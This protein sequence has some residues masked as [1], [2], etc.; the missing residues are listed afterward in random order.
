MRS[1]VV[2]LRGIISFAF[3]DWTKMERGSPCR[4]L[5]PIGTRTPSSKCPM[6]TLSTLIVAPNARY[7]DDPK[8]LQLQGRSQLATRWM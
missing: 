1:L 2:T 7:N 8:Q 4:L 3:K 5:F 6:M